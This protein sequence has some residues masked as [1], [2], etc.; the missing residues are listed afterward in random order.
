MDSFPYWFQAEALCQLAT[1]VVMPRQQ[2][3]VHT[4]THFQTRISQMGRSPILLDAPLSACQ[5]HAIRTALR[6]GDTQ[7]SGLP[8]QVLQRLESEA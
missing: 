3:D 2:E 1:L 7:P 6:H 5:S 8:F 4:F